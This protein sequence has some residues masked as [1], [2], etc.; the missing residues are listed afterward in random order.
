MAT[1][2]QLRARV[3]E[4]A[5]RDLV[6]LDRIA[7]LEKAL[8]TASAPRVGVTPREVELADRVVRLERQLKDTAPADVD[9][10]VSS[11]RRQLKVTQR[12]LDDAMG[13]RSAEIRPVP[14]QVTS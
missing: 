14:G 6:R 4:L 5:A 1:R 10:E 2:R 9:A 11:L 7:E 3:A 8:R 12:Q 13:L